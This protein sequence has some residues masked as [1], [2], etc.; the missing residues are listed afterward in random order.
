MTFQG[1]SKFA[2]TK[3]G[4]TELAFYCTLIC[5][6]IHIIPTIHI[7]YIKYRY[8][9]KV[10]KSCLSLITYARILLTNIIS[11]KYKYLRY[12][13]FIYYSEALHR[14]ALKI[15]IPLFC[16]FHTQILYI[17]IC[18][19]LVQQVYNYYY[20]YYIIIIIILVQ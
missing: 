5:H 8:T 17:Y 19:S 1:S 12:I 15:S 18:I 14:T 16:K 6:T 7:P 10:N 13:L 20:Y 4:W 11:Y 2:W 3:K 9:D